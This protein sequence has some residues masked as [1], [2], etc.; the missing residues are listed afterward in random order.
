[1]RTFPLKSI[2]IEEAKKKQFDLID[3]VTRH[4]TGEESLSL[5]DLGVRGGTN[6]PHQT[7][8]VENVLAEY[9]GAEKAL[10]VRGAGTGALRWG[11]LSHLKAGEKVLVH[12][13]PVYPTTLVNLEAMGAQIIVADFNNLEEIERVILEHEEDL[14]A[15]LIQY[16]RQKIDDSY[17]MEEVI[18]K[19]KKTKKDMVITTDDNYAVMKVD[20][21]GCELGADMSAFSTFKLLGPEGV[22][23]IVGKRKYLEKVE[24][25]NYSGGSQVQ[26]Y[27]AMEVL[28]GL[29]YAPVSLAIQ[30][31]V[32]EELCRRLTD[33]EL[34]FVRSACLANAQ[35][36]VLLVEFKEEI[37][38]KMLIET[39][40]LGGL[41][42]PVG[43]ESKYEFAPLFYRLSGTFR[44]SDASLE[45]R[46]I[47]IN[48]NRSGSETI[49]KILK[50]SYKRVVEG[51]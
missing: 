39:S 20:K 27:E 36:K 35:S 16:T 13:A 29:T 17:D 25:L 10:L 26:G 40:K 22:G 33:K 28:R 34:P 11:V 47:R 18:T 43:A 1:M 31:Q 3:V 2:E 7:I 23:C 37:A 19:I 15:A 24:K 49:I 8:K 6:K 4:F 50:G 5:G 30:N 48:P 46:M 41:P 51:A 38:E 12:D 32:N 14:G 42:N 21:I 44:K 45:K 9:F